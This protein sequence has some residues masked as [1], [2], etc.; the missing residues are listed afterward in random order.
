MTHPSEQR[1]ATAKGT[2]DVVIDR[3]VLRSGTKT[4]TI[5]RLSCMLRVSLEKR[6]LVDE[7]RN[8]LVIVSSAKR[9]PPA[10]LSSSA[11]RMVGYSSDD[12][13]A[14]LKVYSD[15]QHGFDRPYVVILP[16]KILVKDML[17]RVA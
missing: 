2:S 6:H 15:P 10:V 3:L 9:V 14:A 5:P 1:S 11:C 17:C 4:N 16:H 7:E 13:P 12:P 8:K